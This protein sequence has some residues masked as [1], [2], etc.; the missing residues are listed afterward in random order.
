MR[1]TQGNVVVE[2][3][4]EI[5][6][7][8]AFVWNAVR[9]L[10]GLATPEGV[11]EEARAQLPADGELPA[12]VRRAAQHVSMQ[13]RVTEIDEGLMLLGLEMTSGQNV[14]WSSYQSRVRIEPLDG[15][16]TRVTMTCL[17]DAPGEQRR[18]VEGLLRSVLVLSLQSLRQRMEAS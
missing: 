11:V 10:R 5:D 6:R 14:P 4:E 7:P 16:T 13:Q 8:A 15:R 2:S 1:S 12:Q 9:G 3:S 18:L 17:A